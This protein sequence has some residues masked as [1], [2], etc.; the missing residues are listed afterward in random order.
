MWIGQGHQ[1]QWP[2]EL[3]TEGLDRSLAEDFEWAEQADLTMDEFRAA[4]LMTLL[5]CV[6]QAGCG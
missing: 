2:A 5:A 1:N 3:F 4:Y 6:P